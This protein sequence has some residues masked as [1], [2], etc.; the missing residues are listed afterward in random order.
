MAKRWM[1]ELGLAAVFLA[2]TATL[3]SGAAARETLSFG[4]DQ[5]QAVDFYAAP[6]P[7][8]DVPLV[9][10]IHGGGWRIGT[11][12]YVQDKPEFFNGLGYAFASTGYRLV[13]DGTVEE[14]AADIAS[15]VALLRRR[16]RALGFDGDRIVLV[17][18]SAGAHLAALAA[19]LARLRASSCSMARGMTC[20]GRWR[21]R[22]ASWGVFTATLSVPTMPGSL[23]SHRPNIPRGPMRRTG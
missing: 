12:G 6:N 3:S 14:Q 2:S 21:M 22:G 8:A 5:H 17:G 1:A 9:L 16:A 7:G 10:F 19:T 20:R 15:A 4:G 11:R 18:H 13:P 23:R